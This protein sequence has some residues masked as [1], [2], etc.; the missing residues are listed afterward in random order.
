MSPTGWVWSDLALQPSRNFTACLFRPHA[1]T[2]AATTRRSAR[3][4]ASP[5]FRSC[6]SGGTITSAT[7]TPAW[8]RQFSTGTRGRDRPLPLA[9]GSNR[10]DHARHGA[11]G[12]EPLAER[13]V[14]RLRLLHGDP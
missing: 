7:T 13:R 4:F 12:T 10:Q 11:D 9:S 2:V 3:R 8:W 1:C 5:A 6:G 14:E